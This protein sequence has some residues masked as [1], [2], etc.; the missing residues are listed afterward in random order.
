MLPAES[1]W[2]CPNVSSDL[3]PATWTDCQL[4]SANNNLAQCGKHSF[5]VI[6]EQVHH[7]NNWKSVTLLCFTMKELCFMLNRHEDTSLN[8]L[9]SLG[10]FHLGSPRPR[11]WHLHF[12]KSEQLFS[13][14]SITSAAFKDRLFYLVLEWMCVQKHSPPSCKAVV[15]WNWNWDF[16]NGWLPEYH[17]IILC[18]GESASDITEAIN[19]SLACS[20]SLLYNQNSAIW[21]DGIVYVIRCCQR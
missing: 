14:W 5:L 8:Y 3:W 18:F 6:I 17:M 11:W 1:G 9:F 15:K 2:L 21:Y 13:E 4:S 19:L 7:A 20:V 12:P 10:P 16:A